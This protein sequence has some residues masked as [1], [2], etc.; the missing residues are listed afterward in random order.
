MSS[1]S[2]VHVKVRFPKRSF[3]ALHFILRHAN[4]T[5]YSFYFRRLWRQY[6]RVKRG[7]GKSGIKAMT[8]K[9]P[10]SSLPI[11]LSVLVWL[12]IFYLCH[13]GIR[14][15]TWLSDILTNLEDLDEKGARRNFNS[16]ESPFDCWEHTI[17]STE[18]ELNSISVEGRL[19]PIIAI[20]GASSSILFWPSARYSPK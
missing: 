6:W 11:E 16:S 20:K 9:N 12:V 8:S 2:P 17:D 10:R 19:D 1:W 18:L 13:V 3:E 14:W 15:D 4:S 7:P 5:H